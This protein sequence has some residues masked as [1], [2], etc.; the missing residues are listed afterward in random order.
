MRY[1]E[2]CRDFNVRVKRGKAP[3]RLTPLG[4]SKLQKKCWDVLGSKVKL[5]YVGSRRDG[6]FSQSSSDLDIWI[7]AQG[8]HP[9]KFT[10]E[11]KEALK[12]SV[13]QLDWVEDVVAGDV[14]VKFKI[15]D[16]DENLSIAVDL[17]LCPNDPEDFPLLRGSPNR[18]ENDER[19]DGFMLE[20]PTA[21]VAVS[22]VKQLLTT[23]PKGIQLKALVRRVAL[24]YNFS[25]S[26]RS[27]HQA[28][29]D[30]NSEAF[31]L[32]LLL[33]HELRNWNVSRA[34]GSDLTDD[35]AG[36]P[37][38]KQHA[39]RFERAAEEI[40]RA[41]WLAC[42]D[43]LEEE[44]G[45]IHNT[46]PELGRH[47]DRHCFVLP[48]NRSEKG[49]SYKYKC[50]WCQDYN[51]G[52]G[53]QPGDRCKICK[54]VQIEHPRFQEIKQ[55]VE[56]AEARFAASADEPV[57]GRYLV[58]MKTDMPKGTNQSQSRTLATN[59]SS[60]DSKLEAESHVK[61]FNA[62]ILDCMAVCSSCSG[63]HDLQ[64]SIFATLRR[65]WDQLRGA[66][67]GEVITKLCHFYQKL[68]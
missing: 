14:S 2:L 37:K 30:V 51:R 23:R 7:T 50:I 55:E 31:E 29:T 64:I 19:V 62:K 27:K 10:T 46:R 16:P 33:L 66:K 38:R 58:K 9:F 42:L 36:H 28:G 54:Q 24:Y 53:L 25:V 20:H 67:P 15:R 22:G 21:G 35:L 48:G 52:V 49:G 32:F 39:E 65:S 4:F 26:D 63:Y 59:R 56:L 34:F 43:E 40:D 8:N 3:Y 61:A 60:C 13:A 6:A 5:S 68:G 47:P 11:R 57:R 44:S 12:K 1:A 17:A 45:F 41:A 18:W